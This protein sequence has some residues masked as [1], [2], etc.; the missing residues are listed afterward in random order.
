MAI[1]V[2]CKKFDEKHRVD[3]PKIKQR[4][5]KKKKTRRKT[6]KTGQSATDNWRLMVQ[7]GRDENDAKV[8]IN[9]SRIKTTQKT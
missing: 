3:V 2:I 9:K 7:K 4:K 5:K 1:L 6:R 8:V